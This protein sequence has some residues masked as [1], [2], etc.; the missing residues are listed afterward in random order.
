[1]QL[2]GAA[3]HRLLWVE[4]RRENVVFDNDLA[5]PLLGGGDRVGHHGHHA[6][7]G[8]PHDIVE[9]VGVVGVDQM[10]AVDGGVEVLA[11]HV[12]PGVHAVHTG[13]RECR[14]L[15]DGDDARVSVR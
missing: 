4:N 13:H 15:V 8:E 14:G 5:A 10:I 12:F 11:R 2:W 1:V 9:D 7:A 6:L 3:S